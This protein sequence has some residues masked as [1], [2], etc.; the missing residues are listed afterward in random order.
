MVDVAPEQRIAKLGAELELLRSFALAYV[1]WAELDRLSDEAL[2][3]GPSKTSPE[4]ASALLIRQFAATDRL[5]DAA[6]AWL[7]SVAERP[8]DRVRQELRA[9]ITGDM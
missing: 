6:T 8:D 3:E 1:E 2:R 7:A 4:E 9:R 5:D